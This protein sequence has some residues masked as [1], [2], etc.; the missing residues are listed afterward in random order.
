MN[1]LRSSRRE[2]L[3]TAMQLSATCYIFHFAWV[4]HTY[5]VKSAAFFLTFRMW[6]HNCYELISVWE[7]CYHNQCHCQSVVWLLPRVTFSHH[8]PCVSVLVFEQLCQTG[9][10]IWLETKP[11]KEVNKKEFSLESVVWP[12]SLHVC[13]N[14]CVSMMKPAAM[15]DS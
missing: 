1:F 13:L 8:L 12:E 5:V 10:R 11:A 4:P 3:E 6:F 9:E 7:R 15:P 2:S 14:A